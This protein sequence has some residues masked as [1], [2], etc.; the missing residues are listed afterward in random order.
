MKLFYSPGACSMAPHIVL[1]EIGEPFELELVLS[2]GEHEGSMTATAERAKSID[3]SD[4]YISTGLCLLLKKHLFHTGSERAKEI[5]DNWAE[6][7]PKFIKV[8][9]VDYRMALE[10]M[11]AKRNVQRA[12]AA[13]GGR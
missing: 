12:V 6:Y 4:P 1:E 7:L 2:R 9:P 5:L 8:M 3:F 10:Q 13:A 11:Q